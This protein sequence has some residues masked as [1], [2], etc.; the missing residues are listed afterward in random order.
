V[1][2]KNREDGVTDPA[3]QA[4]IN[5]AAT[6]DEAFAQRDAFRSET[7]LPRVGL[8]GNGIPETLIAAAGGLPIHISMGRAEEKS[9]IDSV[10]EPFVDAEVRI[11]LNR[12]MN[13][14]F[15]ECRGI[16]FARDDAPALIAY[17]YATEW[18]RQGKAGKSVPPLFLW[19]LVHTDTPAVQRFNEI[20]AEKL[21]DFLARIGLSQ[22][23]PDMI[24]AAAATETQR[25]TALAQVQAAAGSALSG[26]TLLRWRNAGRF[27]PA[28]DHARLLEATLH[29]APEYVAH[30]VRLG[31][32]GSPLSCT[33][34]Y[35]TLESFGPIVCD[36]QPLGSVWPGP[37]NLQPELAGILKAIAG[38]A[39]CPRITPSSAHRA[40]LVEAL[41][42]ARCDLVVCQLAQ[43][44]DSFGWEIPG[45]AADLAARGITFVNL[46]FR[47]P[48]PDTAWRARAAKRVA[49]ALEVR[50]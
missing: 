31:M 16:V 17:Q 5:A 20:Q 48:E 49:T 22:P 15:A 12:L 30:G 42:N 25:R 10:I 1:N 2:Y 14:A 39:S 44:D 38:D 40:K 50:T 24:A 26:A 47:D 4:P 34:T 41:A 3:P 43:T 9:E 33:A 36:L 7:D 35:E 8:F 32:V 19:N 45:L 6:L 37:G 28:S 11:F 23:E 18:V 27:M 29:G 13:G 21:F 46:G